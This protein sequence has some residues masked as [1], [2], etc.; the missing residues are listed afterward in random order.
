MVP[1]QVSG[2]CGLCVSKEYK[3]DVDGNCDKR[4]TRY[5]EVICEFS[6]LCT[7]VNKSNKYDM[8]H[9]VVFQLDD[10]WELM[11]I[12]KCSFKLYWFWYNTFF[13]LMYF[14]LDYSH[15]FGKISII[16][17]TFGNSVGYVHM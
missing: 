6:V 4:G 5:I 15:S 12:P 11:C 17:L 9:N 3:E 13:R 16:V 1:I 7:Q 8:F 2:I 10:V 14:Y